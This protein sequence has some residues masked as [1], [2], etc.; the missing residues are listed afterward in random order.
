M[1]S[2]PVI[3]DT[4][5]GLEK[6]KMMQGIVD[7]KDSLYKM[8]TIEKVVNDTSVGLS[9]E[10]V[11]KMKTSSPATKIPIGSVRVELH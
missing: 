5:K 9:K 7:V 3:T 8:P 4:M 6:P 1:E 11:F 10:K 2:A